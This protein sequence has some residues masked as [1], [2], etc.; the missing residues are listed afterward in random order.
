[1]LSDKA[2]RVAITHR[3]VSSSSSAPAALALSFLPLPTNKC[4]FLVWQP[5]IFMNSSNSS[6]RRLQQL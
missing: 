6:T 4:R 5:S 2:D 3:T 1:M